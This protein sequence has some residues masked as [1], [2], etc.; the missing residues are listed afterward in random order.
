M[1][2]Q[3][4]W[5]IDK[6]VA[7]PDKKHRYGSSSRDEFLSHQFPTFQNLKS[8]TQIGGHY[9]V[10]DVNTRYCWEA[11]PSTFS[12]VEPNSIEN[13]INEIS[14]PCFLRGTE[15]A[16]EEYPYGDGDATTYADL[17]ELLDFGPFGSNEDNV[18][19][20]YSYISTDLFPPSLNSVTNL[21]TPCAVSD[22]HLICWRA[23]I[24]PLLCS[25]QECPIQGEHIINYGF[26]GSPILIDSSGLNVCLIEDG[27]LSC[28]SG[29]H[30]V[31]LA[32]STKYLEMNLNYLNVPAMG[33][34]G[35]LALGLSMLGLGA[36]RLRRK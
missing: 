25:P 5:K 27:T 35:L 28:Y 6:G 7:I 10:L 22:N 16:C 36:L 24:N 30:H 20:G 18:G 12:S 9:C 17:I 34:I 15:L 1:S 31:T 19:Y 32:G 21:S 23:M 3:T 8:I 4:D 29:D 33:G 26:V 13:N 2:W 11:L 14:G